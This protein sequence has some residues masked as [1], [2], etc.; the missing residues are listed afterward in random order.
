MDAGE[1]DTVCVC[2]LFDGVGNTK[3]ASVPQLAVVPPMERHDT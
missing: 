3:S 2:G 1:I